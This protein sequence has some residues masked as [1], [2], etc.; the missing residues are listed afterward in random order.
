MRFKLS[1][2]VIGLILISFHGFAQYFQFSQD[3]FTQ[4]RINPATVAASDYA[5]A[6]LIYRQQKASEGLQIKS[7]FLEGSYPLFKR[8]GRWAGVGF[9]LLDDRA[10][11]GGMFKTQEIG[12]SYAL[13]VPLK[14]HSSLN[15]GFRT[16]YQNK[17]VSLD[18]LTT[19]YQFVPGHGMVGDNNGEDLD[20]FR[21]DFITFSSGIYWQSTDKLHN[22][23]AYAGISF[24]DFNRPQES[25]YDTGNKLPS[26]LIVNAGV[27]I[28]E[29]EAFSIL[30]ELVFTHSA[31][32]GML[33][34]GSV[35]TYDLYKGI[36]SSRPGKV[37]LITKYATGEYIIAGVQF[38][39]ERFVFGVSYDVP[40]VQ[41]GSNQGS[42]ELGAEFKQLIKNSRKNKEKKKKRTTKK[43]KAKAVKKN[44][45]SVARKPAAKETDNRKTTLE[46]DDPATGTKI[47]EAE[48]T[49][50]APSPIAIKEAEKEDAK[51]DSMISED[52]EKKQVETTTK[53]GKIHHLPLA[54]EEAVL[55]FNFDFGKVQL[56]QESKAYL[57]ELVNVLEEDD[58]LKVTI[59]GHTD[60]VGSAAFNQNLSLERARIVRDFLIAEGIAEDRVIVEGKGESAPLVENNT[61]EN[62]AKNRRVDFKIGYR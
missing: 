58:L 44:K 40:L 17:K 42:I 51:T 8:S 38:E 30:P 60:D 6:A 34:I 25:F 39:K 36:H 54:L 7:T 23:I 43:K 12:L 16:V 14:K 24:F 35:F 48:K 57:L 53:S 20:N 62:R 21:T 13:S 19:G 47:D 5:R 45:Q 9:S 41:G 29:N 31:S 1:V 10:G 55:H 32:K 46:K 3:N 61:P 22:K 11:F 18:R 52:D 28:Y 27:K 4:Q 49:P 33:N 37:N 50:E 59:T 26:T 2:L 15:L 56:N